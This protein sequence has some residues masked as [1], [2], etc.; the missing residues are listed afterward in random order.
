MHALS[1]RIPDML[2]RDDYVRRSPAHFGGPAGHKEW[3]HF[4]VLGPDLDL[5]VNFSFCDDVRSDRARNEEVARVIVLARHGGW[6]GDID[7]F[8]ADEVRV[9]HAGVDIALGEN[10]LVLCDGTYHLRL[11]LRDRPIAAE[12][13]LRPL[14]EPA[15]APN[16]P[17]RDGPPLHWVVTPRLVATGWVTIGRRT[18]R[19]SDTLAY[20]DHNFGHFRW[21][22]DFSW[23]WAFALPDDGTVPWTVA[24]ATLA[25]RARNHAL[26]QGVFVWRGARLCR[27]FR[28]GDIT[29]ES[30]PEFL[31]LPRVFKI[32]RV[33]A[34]LSPDV[35]TDV[36]RA[37]RL[38]AEAEGDRVDYEF[39]PEDIGQVVIPNETDLDVTILNETTGRSRIHGEIRGESFA[40]DGRS[41]FEF[42]GA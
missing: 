19:L 17:L 23:R 2:A 26:S 11:R 6:D 27:T 28:D 30:S 40:A 4:C 14:V 22:Q 21:G 38:R 10:R 39:S 13:V 29:I 1:S 36:P 42:L 35:P 3:L 31:A 8:A 20:H 37:V 16:I 25:S 41:V 24:F 9:A 18:V 7:A 34:L 32:P 5:L 33:M 12:L 15:R